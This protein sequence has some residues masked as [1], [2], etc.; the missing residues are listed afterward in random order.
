MLEVVPEGV[1]KWAGMRLLLKHLQ[2]APHQL[3]AV[4]SEH[5]LHPCER[6]RTSPVEADQCG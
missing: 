2:L 1:D 5:L 6:Q 4:S 3:M